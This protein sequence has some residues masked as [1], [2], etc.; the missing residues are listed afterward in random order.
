[1]AD[2]STEPDQ[3]TDG[4]HPAPYEGKERRG[5]GAARTT[6]LLF[7]AATAAAMLITVAVVA[8][9]SAA[10]ARD[11]A[12]SLAEDV[13][14]SIASDFATPSVLSSL[15]AGDASDLAEFRNSLSDRM[16]DGSLLAFMLRTPDG[17][18]V[19]SDDPAAPQTMRL[20]GAER[21]LIGT[22]D[23]NFETA[24]ANPSGSSGA[25]AEPERYIISRTVMSRG[26]TELL[27]T[28]GLPK[29]ALDERAAKS[30]A[31]HLPL[32][33]GA[34]GLL[35]LLLLPIVYWQA[36]RMERTAGESRRLLRNAI[37]VAANE[38]SRVARDL[39]DDVIP[40]LAGVAYGLSALPSLAPQG[41]S[42]AMSQII[43]HSADVLRNDVAML[44]GMLV[45]L[46]PAAL[47]E[48]EIGTWLAALART[49]PLPGVDV[50]TDIDPDMT[51]SK[52]TAEA[53]HRVTRE[54][55]RNIA[56]HAGAEVVTVRAHPIDDAVE[57]VIEDDG[58][59]FDTN[60]STRNGHLGLSLIRD[61]VNDVGGSLAIESSPG[62]GT[63]LRATIRRE[64]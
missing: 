55:L 4:S 31:K 19:F 18:V 64:A 14:D 47:A 60:N 9:V 10:I 62:Q 36:K 37:D 26:G 46:H 53:L 1:M 49:V 2:A 35:A 6:L 24:S 44:R 17:R 15:V 50:R 8:A 33:L 25:T 58:A 32:A 63:T 45:E 21:A 43:S 22:G 11:E 48:G 5:R 41:L 54:A 28:L 52:R 42:P 61:T 13:A 16:A 57:L 40:D 59:G 27:L 12:R 23:T 29:S 30:S 51:V 34:A 38:R 39:H 20:T 56:K 7:F 3:G